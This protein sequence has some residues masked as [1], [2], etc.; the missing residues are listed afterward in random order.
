MNFLAHLYLS[1]KN[2]PVMVGNFIADMVKGRQIE[3]FDKEI[4]RGIR[5]HRAIDAFTDSHPVVEASKARLRPRYRKYAGVLVDMY[6]D[7]FLASNWNDYTE[8]HLNDFVR[9]AYRM[10]C[11]HVLVLPPRA[12]RIL[13][14]MITSNWLQSYANLDSLQKILAQMAQRT[15][16]ESGMENAVTE[17]KLH[18]DLFKEEFET[19]FPDLVA[20]VYNEY[21]IELPYNGIVIPEVSSETKS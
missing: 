10:L 8:Q 14:F 4:R 16:F 11:R 15:T 1:G 13:P 18:Y 7:H 3:K 20:F 19:F 9:K 5:I 17:L 2:E 12:K 21:G 6:Y